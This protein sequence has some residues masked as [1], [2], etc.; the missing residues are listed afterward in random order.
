MVPDCIPHM[1]RLSIDKSNCQH[2]QNLRMLFWP[3]HPLYIQNH[4]H[5]LHMEYPVVHRE[6]QK[7]K[8]IL[9]LYTDDD[10]NPHFATLLVPSY[11]NNLIHQIPA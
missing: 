3:S 4:R 8:D 6:D 1:N 5:T 2:L 9:Y 10:H 11:L 7:E